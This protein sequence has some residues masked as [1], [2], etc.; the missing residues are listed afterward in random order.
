MIC[1]WQTLVRVN[2]VL[3][4][5]FDVNKLW[6]IVAAISSLL[7][8]IVVTLLPTLSN[9]LEMKNAQKMVAR[10]LDDANSRCKSILDEWGKYLERDLT[11]GTGIESCIAIESIAKSMRTEIWSNFRFRTGPEAYWCFKPFFVSIDYIRDPSLGLITD[12]PKLYE[13]PFV[14]A[15]FRADQAKE[16]VKFYS[17]TAAKCKYFK[18]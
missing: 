9:H 11:K 2:P 17:Q 1:I 16:F 10:E 15:R 7:T 6:E 12:N 5:I 18:C 3:E 14:L 8:V 4:H 13:D